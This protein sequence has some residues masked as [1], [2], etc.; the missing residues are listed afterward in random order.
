M[1]ADELHVRSRAGAGTWVDEA[2]AAAAATYQQRSSRTSY[3]E[4]VG[5][6]FVCVMLD[7]HEY[8]TKGCDLLL[9]TTS[10]GS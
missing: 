5:W 9:M 6:H 10:S 8:V 2:A 7:V 4:V 1:A 3:P